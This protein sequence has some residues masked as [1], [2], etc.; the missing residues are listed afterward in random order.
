M[1]LQTVCVLGVLALFGCDT[2]LAPPT[3]GDA[4]DAAV[5][6]FTGDVR[7]LRINATD[8]QAWVYVHLDEGL[9]AEDADWDLAFRRFNIRLNGGAGGAGAGLTQWDTAGSLESMVQAPDSGWSTDQPDADEDGDLEL[10]MD[11]WWAYNGDLHGLTPEP[12]VWFVRG[13]EGQRYYTFR[14]VDYYDA[15][16]TAANLLVEWRA[17]TAPASPPPIE[18]GD[19]SLEPEPEPA[20]EWPALSPGELDIDAEDDQVWTYVK[21]LPAPTAVS[22]AEVWD[23]GFKRTLVRTNGGTSGAGLA[24][25]LELLEVPW[26]AET[27]PTVGYV[28]DANTPIPGPPGSGSDDANQ[29]LTRWYDYDGA[30]HRLFPRDTTYAVR[31]ADGAYAQLQFTEYYLGKYRL[32]A[33]PLER[34]VETVSLDFVLS[35]AWAWFDLRL[36]Q[37]VSVADFASSTE[38]DLGV[39]AAGVRTAGGAYRV[40]DVDAL[41]SVASADAALCVADEVAGHVAL[42]DWASGGVFVVCVGSDVVRLQISPADAVSTLRYGY[43]GP[44]MSTF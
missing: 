37:S 30:N 43:A 1:R 3:G 6:D 38:W 16:G 23:V 18:A 40:P 29:I 42:S 12:G 35:D 28:V 20:P 7:S 5:G 10:A 26:G 9:V 39:S 14:V 27:A 44:G 11:D 15:A 8:E 33:A 13:F 22:E 19:P 17:A 21:L 2:D 36:G 31:T 32:R 4:V 25:V 34:A 41:E 24:G